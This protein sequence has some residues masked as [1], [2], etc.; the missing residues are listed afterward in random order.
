MKHPLLRSLPVAALCLVFFLVLSSISLASAAG[1]YPEDIAARLQ[2]KY[3][4]M[5]SLSFTFN[6]Q[7]QGQISGRPRTGSGTAFFY[8]T[9]KNS[10]MRWNYTT[11]DKQVLISDGKTFSMYFSELEQMIV[12]PADSL[13]SDLTY[14][15]FSGRGRIADKFHI[16]PPDEELMQEEMKAGQPQI[17]KLVP[18]EPQSQVQAI[19]LW[20]DDDSLIR[21]IEIKDHF[22]TVTLLTLSK[23][24]I[25]T[26]DGSS[27]EVAKLFSFT[28]PEGTEIIHQ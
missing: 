4:Q 3:D 25:D 20:V 28:P 1:E 23:I 24:E 2:K 26:I 15:F 16:L 12:T 27:S 9:G 6:Q 10:K 18:K 19:H 21:R 14:T 8:K 22:D 11:P 7:S 13:E 17:I 5:R